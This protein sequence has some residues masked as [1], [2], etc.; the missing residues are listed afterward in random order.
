MFGAVV[1]AG[2]SLL[3]GKAVEKVG[4]EALK[5]ASSYNVSNRG[6]SAKTSSGKCKTKVVAVIDAVVE[7]QFDEELSPILNSLGVK[8]RTPKLALEV[9][10]HLA[11]NTYE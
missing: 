4:S 5:V 2:S 8:N 6:Y 9:A 11:E 1:K 10:Q 7:V 3:A